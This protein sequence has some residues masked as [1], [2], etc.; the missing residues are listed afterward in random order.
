[1]IVNGEQE[2]GNR[3]CFIARCLQPQ[4]SETADMR[5]DKFRISTFSSILEDRI[6]PDTGISQF[7]V[8]FCSKHAFK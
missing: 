4:E 5:G 7:S 3:I 1:M 6:F 8:Y 2:D